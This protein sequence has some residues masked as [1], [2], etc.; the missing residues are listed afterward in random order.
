MSGTRSIGAG[1]LVASILLTGCGPAGVTE[2]TYEVKPLSAVE[3]A[4]QL[5]QNYAQGAP[6]SS[7][8]TSFP[9]LISEVKETDP[10][11]ADLLEKGFADIQQSPANRAAT[12][13]ALLE[14][15]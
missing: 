13:K 12:A 5:L 8:V 4:R 6:L 7:E 11:K 9:D 1:L 14:K 3:Q 2:K 15:L 10:Q